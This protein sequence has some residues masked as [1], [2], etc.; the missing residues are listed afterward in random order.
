V[1]KVQKK[2]QPRGSSCWQSAG[3][4]AARGNGGATWRG[5]EGSSTG[6]RAA[7]QVLG[8]HVAQ[9]EAARGQQVLGTWPARAAGVGR[10]ENRERGLEVDEGG[11]ICNL[12]K[13]QGLH[14]KA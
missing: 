11:L 1:V 4:V 12:S 7:A 5:R 8:R 10:R 3:G 9:R 2:A 6:W 14:C 13:V